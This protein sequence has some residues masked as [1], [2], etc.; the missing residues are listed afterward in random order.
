MIQPKPPCIKS[1]NAVFAPQK[2][3]FKGKKQIFLKQI[4]FNNKH[5]SGSDPLC[6][7]GLWCSGWS[8]D[9]KPMKGHKN[10]LNN[11]NQTHTI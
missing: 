10:P 1:L 4:A 8:T 7:F 3:A 2:V 9:L 5:L 6:H 11:V